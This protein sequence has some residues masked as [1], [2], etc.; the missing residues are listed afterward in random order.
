M[1]YSQSPASNT[2]TIGSFPLGLALQESEDGYFVVT[3]MARSLGALQRGHELIAMNGAS[4]AN[5]SL[6]DLEKLLGQLRKERKTVTFT[7]R[8]PPDDANGPLFMPFDEP[9]GD[10]K[11]CTDQTT[12]MTESNNLPERITTIRTSAAMPIHF[13]HAVNTTDLITPNDLKKTIINIDS[14]FRD[15]DQQTSTNFTYRMDPQIK[16][17]IRIKLVSIEFP[18]VFYTFSQSRGNTQFSVSIGGSSVPILIDDGNYSMTTIQTAIQASLDIASPLLGIPS[19]GLAIAVDPYNGRVSISAP[20]TFTLDFGG[21]TLGRALG[22]NGGIYSG[23]LSYTGESTLDIYGEQYALFQLNDFNNV[24]QRMKDK[25]IVMAFAK[26]ILKSG[27]FAVNYDDSSNLLTKEIIFA[28]PNNLS[29]LTII[30]R[31][32]Y[33]GIINNGGIHISFALE[34]TEVMN[35]KLYD[36]YRN[37]LLAK[38]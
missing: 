6:K 34:V 16:N 7:Y 14:R 37:Y 32:A 38:N 19:P 31:D 13:T 20:V 11:C 35:C 36:Y 23:T 10:P 2:V 30:F 9:M 5:M 27:K 29:Q 26:I 18:N 28:Q 25:N 1:D 22:F 8:R 15:S 21:Y 12:A 4:L 24:E 33:G 3:N 17:V